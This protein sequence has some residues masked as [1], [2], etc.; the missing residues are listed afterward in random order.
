MR[1]TKDEA[2][3]LAA[4]VES[5]KF[6]TDADVSG[7]H[8]RRKYFDSLEVLQSKLEEAGRDK[9]RNGRKSM[10]DFSDLVKR[11]INTNLTF[12]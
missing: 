10:N 11:F 7:F 8:E 3:I 5:Y 9:R 4:A 12:I 1:L 6:S 2:R